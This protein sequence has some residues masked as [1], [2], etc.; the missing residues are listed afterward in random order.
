MMTSS[1]SNTPLSGSEAY[2]ATIRRRRSPAEEALVVEAARAGSS[3]ARAQV[4][5]ICRARAW[6]RAVS[7]AAFYWA[8]RGEVLDPQ[9]IAQEAML[10]AWRRMDKA[11]VAPNP[12][13]YLMRTLEGAMLTFCREQQNAI[14]VPACQQSRGRLPLEVI[15]LDAPL[16]GYDQVTLADLLPAT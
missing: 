13:G 7:L 6:V 2:R 1:Q 11:L 15:S 16:S 12:I 14:R 9:D 5:E 8:L 3:S 10:R 4:L